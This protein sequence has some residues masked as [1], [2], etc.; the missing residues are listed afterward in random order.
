MTKREGGGGGGGFGTFREEGGADIV[1]AGVRQ[2]MIE[3]GGGEIT[4]EVCVTE[5][6]KALCQKS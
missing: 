3:R 4:S 6:S 2:S 5:G 1:R